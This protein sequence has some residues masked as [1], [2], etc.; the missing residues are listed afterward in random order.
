MRL[1]CTEVTHMGVGKKAKN[2]AET[3]R[4]KAKETT[5]RAVGNKTLEAKGR[6]KQAKGDAKQAAEKGKDTLKH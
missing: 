3:L 6:G 1:T 5:G 4:G 2:T